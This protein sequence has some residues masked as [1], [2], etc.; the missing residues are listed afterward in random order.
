[1]RISVP[2][3]NMW[4]T[5]DYKNNKYQKTFSFTVKYA[6]YLELFDKN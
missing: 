5:K 4:P 1:M 6:K 2:E 3:E